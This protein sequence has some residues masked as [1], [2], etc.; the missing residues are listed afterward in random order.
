MWVAGLVAA[1]LAVFVVVAFTPLLDR[2]VD[3]RTAP[4]DSYEAGMQRAAALLAADGDTVNPV[5]R[6]RVLDQGERTQKAVVLLHGFT[7]C[8]AQFDAIAQV[9]ADAGYSV[10]VP[11]L[12][13]HGESDRL[14][15]SPSAVTAQSLADNGNLAVD[16]AAGLGEEVHVVGLSGGGT[17]AAWLAHERDEVTDAVLIAPLVVPKV[18]PGFTVAPVAR[19][20]R[21]LPDMY[22]W[23]D[24]G[25]K[26][27][28]A[29][30]PYAYPRYSLRALGSFLSLG[31]AVQKTD[32]GRTTRLDRLVVVT[33]ANDAAVNAAGVAAIGDAVAASADSRID[34]RFAA[35]DGFK[36]DL[37]DPQG[38]NAEKLDQIYP[39]L[40]R[41]LGLPGL[42]AA[43]D[44]GTAAGTG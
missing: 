3:N 4:A 35:V 37:I 28:L 10:V 14:T 25:Q 5:C 22:L 33:N 29:K 12:P 21:V 16:I 8:P 18:L 15:E 17:V 39:T 20:V 30:P 42:T 2:P 19:I 27:A 13:G 38:E 26:E 9:Y 32:P 34:H 44:T 24:S 6:S 1:A 41:L 40:G 36:H 7:N 43:E 11:R 31:R 23:W